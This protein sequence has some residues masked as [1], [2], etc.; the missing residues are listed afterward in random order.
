MWWMLLLMLATVVSAQ[1]SVSTS[2]PGKNF[3]IILRK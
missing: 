1:T 3:K 2:S